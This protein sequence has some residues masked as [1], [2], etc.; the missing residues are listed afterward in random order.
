MRPACWRADHAALCALRREVFVGEQRVPEA[1]EWDGL[2]ATATHF[3]AEDASGRPIGVARL[4][5]GGRF[6]RLAVTAPWRGRGVG[7]AL[8]RAG[9]AHARAEGLPELFLD[10]QTHALGFYRRLGLR[11]EGEEFLDAG[12]PH[13]RMRLPLAPTRGVDHRPGEDDHD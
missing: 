8:L 2:D 1:L 11:E 10:A 4:G 9:L 5:A 6:G 12:L 3:L 7:T 13:R